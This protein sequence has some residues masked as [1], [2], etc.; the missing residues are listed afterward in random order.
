MPT[1]L[2][3][4]QEEEPLAFRMHGGEIARSAREFL[5]GANLSRYSEEL[6][7]PGGLTLA[8]VR[9]VTD[10]D[11]LRAGITKEFH[12]KRFL[13]EARQLMPVGDLEPPLPQPPQ[14]PVPQQ[15]I[16]SEGE[17]PEPEL[18]LEPELETSAE[19]APEPEPEPEPEP[20]PA[21]A[22][23]SEPAAVERQ[24]TDTNHGRGGGTGTP[25]EDDADLAE[26]IRYGISVAG[27]L[28]AVELF[29]AHTHPG[30]TTSDICHAYLK[31]ATVPPGWVDAAEL[32][33]V[34]AEGNDISGRCWYTHTYREI[35]T[36]R[37]Q[38][39]APP[40][41]R[42]F[43]ALLEADP[44]TAHLV[45]KPT[46]FLSHAWLYK[47]PN[48]VEALRAWV[49]GQPAGSPEPFFWFDTFSIDEHATQARPQEWWATT[50]KEAIRSMGHTVM[51]LSPWSAP[52]PLT[53]AWCLWELFCTVDTGMEFSVCL[54]P[55]EQEAFEADLYASLY[56]GPSLSAHAGSDDRIITAF[57]QIDVAKAEAGNPDD[58]NMI[59]Q[60]ASS[61]PGAR[62][63]FRFHFLYYKWS[64]Y[65][66]RLGTDI[67]K[68]VKTDR[69]LSQVDVRR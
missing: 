15:P 10:D 53:R 24:P 36:G 34:D 45:G 43:C 50:F 62:K 6:L 12:R 35:A 49:A 60:A 42:S 65:Q 22:P 5:A 1:E 30:T 29:R 21:P 58:L 63:R 8:G 4:E 25:A 27:L 13:R 59:L 38:P 57:S 11:L 32:I 39:D 26:Y 66:D 68:A 41:T 2:E 40:G 3:P 56:D 48:L 64:F 47:F 17:P 52:Q 16:I 37:T 55:A 67:R 46:H 28:H 61:M 19:P 9:A 7:A 20:A 31:P 33:K 51:M 18:E 23:D 14:Q 54:G 44:A 69:S